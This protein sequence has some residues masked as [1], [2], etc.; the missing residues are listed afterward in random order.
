MPHLPDHRNHDPLQIAALAAGDAEGADL[1]QAR[2]LV[3]TCDECAALHHDLRAIS[4]ALPSTPAP[5]RKRDF[6]LTPEQADSLRPAGW[7]RLLAPLAGPRFAF[8]A[9]LGGSLAALGIAGILVAGAASAPIANLNTERQSASSPVAGA[10]SAEATGRLAA[11][12]PTARVDELALPAASAD[13]AGAAPG[14]VDTGPAASAAGGG[15]DGGATSKDL[16][17]PSVPPTVERSVQVE[18]AL[19]VDQPPVIAILSVLLLAVGVVLVVLR[20]AGR[21]LGSD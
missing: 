11:P 10:A 7:R 12:E 21:R 13:P 20:L 17:E 4:V 16:G 2:D 15:Y 19:Q 6:R 8:A 3:A 1:E 5:T 18:A 9:P 14:M